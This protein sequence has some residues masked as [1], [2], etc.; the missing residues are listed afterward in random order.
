MKI[1]K[2]VKYLSLILVMAVA[3]SCTKHTVEYNATPIANK[4]E[5]QLHYIVPVI[6]NSA[7]NINRVVVTNTASP[8]PDSLF[9]NIK[10][11]LATYNAIPS[12]SVGRFYTIAPGTINLKLYMYNKGKTTDSLVYNQNVDLTLGKQNL[13]VHDFTKVPVKFDNGYPFKGNLTER[14]DSTAWI[15][16]YNFLYETKALGPTALKLQYQYIDYRTNLPVNIGPPVAFGETTGWQPITVVKD[17]PISQGSRT[18]TFKIKT[19]DVNGNIVGDLSIMGT[20]GVYTNYTATASIAIARRYHH[21]EA[22]FRATASPN[23]S[24]RIFTAL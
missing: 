11:P 20:G 12:G 14:T 23:S 8:S 15:K 9:S 24:V 1:M 22:G 16:F 10:S 7:Y 3:F 2:I 18:M 4:A 6:A 5:F 17:V 19:V 13:F 21:I